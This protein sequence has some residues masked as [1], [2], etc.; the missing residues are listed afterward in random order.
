MASKKRGQTQPPAPNMADDDKEC[1]FAYA[2]GA[3]EMQVMI[4][5]GGA[6]RF[7]QVT[8]LT[9]TIDST[10]WT[11]L[12]D[13]DWAFALSLYKPCCD[14]L[15]HITINIQGSNLFT[16]LNYI[17]PLFQTTT[18]VFSTVGETT[19]PVCDNHSPTYKATTRKKNAQTTSQS[20]D[21]TTVTKYAH[22]PIPIS[23]VPI[24]IAGEKAIIAALKALGPIPLITITG[25]MELSLR[26][27]L[28]AS[29]NPSW[30]ISTHCL[31]QY[32][33]EADDATKV[34]E[35][36]ALEATT[37]RTGQKMCQ[38]GPTLYQD[39]EDFGTTKTR[40]TGSL[41]GLPATFVVPTGKAGRVVLGW[42]A[43][44]TWRGP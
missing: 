10:T 14:C 18:E 26:R 4:N 36:E 24:Y 41:Y 1:E 23:S 12:E 28:I 39:S 40:R 9:I 13:D 33:L 27:E 43:G 8:N 22:R 16:R 31:A 2:D 19:A 21:S 38:V 7:R 3:V 6:E 29:L 34:V 30:Q 20:P 35:T 44:R 11:D 32:G 37:V 25:P 5:S 42:K 15:E 17:K